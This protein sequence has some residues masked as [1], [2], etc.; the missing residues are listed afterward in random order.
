MKFEFNTQ[1]LAAAIRISYEAINRKREDENYHRFIR[2]MAEL[3]WPA[4]LEYDPWLH[5]RVIEHY[6]E[7]NIDEIHQKQTYHLVN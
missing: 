7:D 5:E 1:K 4:F 6:E 3:D 2:I